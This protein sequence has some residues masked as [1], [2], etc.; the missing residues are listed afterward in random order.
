[1]T[2]A[3]WA[4]PSELAQLAQIADIVKDQLDGKAVDEGLG[5]KEQKEKCAIDP[6]A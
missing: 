2:S 3:E 4:C 6:K 5:A 1:M